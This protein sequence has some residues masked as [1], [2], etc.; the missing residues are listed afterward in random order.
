MIALLRI[1]HT[2][3]PTT[4]KHNHI[5]SNHFICLLQGNEMTMFS[6]R[7]SSCGSESKGRIFLEASHKI[8]HNLFF[9]C[10]KRLKFPITFCNF[11]QNMNISWQGVNS[12]LSHCVE[13][14]VLEAY[15]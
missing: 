4:T 5:H 15:Y 8:F 10:V 1:G 12:H 7:H 11:T 3:P 9:L 13:A 6:G 14:S 2:G